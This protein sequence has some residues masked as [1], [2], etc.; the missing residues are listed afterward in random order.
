[1]AHKYDP[2]VLECSMRS[3]QNQSEAHLTIYISPGIDGII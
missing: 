2:G 1:M 3:F